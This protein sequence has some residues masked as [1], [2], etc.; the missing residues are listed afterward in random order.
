MG[1]SNDMP[2]AEVRALLASTPL[3]AL[4]RVISRF[5]DDP[6]P[7][8]VAGGRVRA[9]KRCRAHRAEDR[10]LA[11]L[12]SL[13]RELPDAGCTCVAGLD[14][15]GRGALAGPVTA[16]AVLLGWDELPPG[17]DDSKRLT[18]QRRVELDL[19]VRA[20]GPRGRDRPRLARGH[21]PARASPS[22]STRPCASRSPSC[23]VPTTRSWTAETGRIWASPRRPSSRA[24]RRSGCIAAA[25]VVA[26]VARDALM[27]SLD[28]EHP[29]YGFA[30][31]KGYGTAEHLAALN[32]LGPCPVHRRSFSPC[33]QPPLF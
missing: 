33:T 13:Q 15:V 16:G 5:R 9:P 12:G 28:A 3:P 4:P 32:E 6:R 17:I 29:G 1:R 31:N 8:V 23:L 2:V 26:K 20:G 14:E 30:V 24:T 21:R 7:G 10:R 19:L 25:S 22:R 18:P 27:V 11:A